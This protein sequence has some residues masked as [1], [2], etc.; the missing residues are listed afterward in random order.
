M[1]QWE[2]SLH[3]YV[4]QRMTPYMLRSQ[5]YVQRNNSFAGRITRYDGSQGFIKNNTKGAPDCIILFNKRF[6]AVEYKTLTGRQSPDQKRIQALI[7]SAGGV[8]TI[9]RRPEDFEAAL[10]ELTKVN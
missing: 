2:N 9:V 7:E 8:Y 3:A 10:K 4:E 1:S 6:W 5:A